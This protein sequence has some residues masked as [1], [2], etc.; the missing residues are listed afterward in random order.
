MRF[1]IGIAYSFIFFASLSSQARDSL[2]RI[3]GFE[4]QSC[5][6]QKKCFRLTSAE[7]ESGALTP[8]MTFFDYQLEIIDA[9]KKRILKGP[10]GYYDQENKKIVLKTPDK[11]ELEINTEDLSETVY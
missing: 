3:Q 9:S 2:S 1:K 4:V 8:L 7:A 5:N 10:R 11:K 6:T